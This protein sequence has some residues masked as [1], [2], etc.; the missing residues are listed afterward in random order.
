MLHS[1]L[2]SERACSAFNVTP[3]QGSPSGPALTASCD[4][5]SEMTSSLDCPFERSVTMRGMDL[6]RRAGALLPARVDVM[7]LRGKSMCD[8]ADCLDIFVS[9]T[10]RYN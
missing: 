9:F 8:T 5:T 3:H 1:R 4:R 6:K 2:A 7:Y 10:R